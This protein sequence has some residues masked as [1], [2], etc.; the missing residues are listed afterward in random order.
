MTEREQSTDGETASLA[1]GGDGEADVAP[2]PPT[3]LATDTE[4]TIRRV[5]HQIR[6]LRS[7]RGL[8]LQAVADHTGV[9][10]SML[11][12]LE[13]GVAGASIGTLVAVSSA[14]GVHMSDLFEI[15]PDQASP[16]RR[17]TEQIEVQTAAGVLRRVAHHDPV[18]GLEMVVNEYAAGTASGAR[19]VHHSG[20]EFGVV[21]AGRLTVEVDGVRYEL[22]PGDAI[23]YRSDQPH[24]ISNEGETVARAVW[25]NLDA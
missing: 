18:R 2:G 7:A 6:Q 10:V 3:A 21:M 23:T 4:L 15:G 12:M 13:R 16:V 5:G 22:H 20:T 9:S 17:R 14:L 19:A 25:V 8:T 24:L 11:S 1:A